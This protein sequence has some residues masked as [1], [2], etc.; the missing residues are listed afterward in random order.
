[1][2]HHHWTCAAANRIGGLAVRRRVRGGLALADDAIDAGRSRAEDV[3][4]TIRPA[5]QRALSEAEGEVSGAVERARAVGGEVL[6]AV[7]RPR[8]ARRRRMQALIGVGA[9]VAAGA[10]LAAFLMRRRSAPDT[11]ETEPAATAE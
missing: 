10:A 6:G 2:S 4:D 8:R 3:L 9:L 5:L 11:T 1:M 7:R